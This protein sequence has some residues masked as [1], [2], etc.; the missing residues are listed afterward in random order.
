MLK[1]ILFALIKAASK[2]L[3]SLHVE[4]Y[5][6]VNTIYFEGWAVWRNY[7]IKFAVIKLQEF[8]I[9]SFGPNSEQNVLLLI[10]SIR[11][12]ISWTNLITNL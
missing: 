4:R 2:I 6:I 10:K 5:M 7:W 3:Y 8:Y 12:L 1:A 9:F 11:R